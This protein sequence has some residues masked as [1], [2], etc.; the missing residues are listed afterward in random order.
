MSKTTYKLID[1]NISSDK[2]K[3]KDTI[4]Y[5]YIGEGSITVV[6]SNRVKS[7][8]YNNH[9]YKIPSSNK[10]LSESL[11][12]NILDI[13]CIIEE[14][15]SV[16]GVISSR[17]I[18]DFSTT[19]LSKTFEELYQEQTIFLTNNTSLLVRLNTIWKDTDNKFTFELGITL[20]YKEKEGDSTKEYTHVLTAD[21]IDSGDQAQIS[22][23]IDGIEKGYSKLTLNNVSVGMSNFGYRV[24]KQ[25][26]DNAYTKLE[27]INE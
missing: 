9:T 12:E 23:Q 13:S 10:P 20:V 25:V 26:G 19:K 5:P 18:T 15:N 6:K 22:I 21:E 7:D 2:Y 16:T 24:Y 1:A 14:K 8:E 27:N 4:I 3:D 17:T 11:I